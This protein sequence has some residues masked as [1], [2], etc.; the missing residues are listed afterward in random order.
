MGNIVVLIKQVP[1]TWSEIRLREENFTLDRDNVDLIIDEI[2]EKAV[3]AA[4]QFQSAVGSG[5]VILISMGPESAKDALRKGLAMGA[6]EGILL[7]DNRISGSD[8]VQT[9]WVLTKAIGTIADLDLII[10]GNYS[11]DGNTGAIPAVIADYLDIP[12]ISDAVGIEYSV[13]EIIV[14]KE[15]DTGIYKLKVALPA[16]IS[17]NEKINE[18]RF[19]NF[20]GIMEAKKKGI[21]ILTLE[22]LGVEPEEVGLDNASVRVTAVTEVETK[23][24]G[25]KIKADD[26]TVE[27]IEN[28]LI[29]KN[30]L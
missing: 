4:L 2:N 23:K 10:A 12:L 5:K 28:F 1:D 30:I 19:P 22:D 15:V 11:T 17:V 27:L 20:K 13:G 21:T 3:E 24:S 18:P 25:K 6:D 7:S 14:D 26:S 8:A 9:G 29:D 16:V